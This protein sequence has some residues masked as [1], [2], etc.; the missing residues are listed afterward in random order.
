[1]DYKEREQRANAI[2]EAGRERV[3]V[4]PAPS[5]QKFLPGSRVRI[6]DDLGSAMSH[7]A[8]GREAT[9]CYTY[10]HAYGGD[11]VK[12]YCLYVDGFGQASWYR[13]DQLTAI[14][15]PLDAEF[16]SE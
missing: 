15:S 7:Y 4:N 5:G 11:D 10:A 13:E 14:D 8:A 1:M 6:A 9:V 2:Y 3:A 16:I 12:S